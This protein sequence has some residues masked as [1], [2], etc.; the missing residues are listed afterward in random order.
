MYYMLARYPEKS[1]LVVF[2]PSN[3]PGREGA[4]KLRTFQWSQKSGDHLEYNLERLLKQTVRVS[5]RLQLE[6]LQASSL[7][8]T[9]K[10]RT[11]AD[12]TV[13]EAIRAQIVSN[14]RCLSLDREPALNGPGM[15]ELNTVKPGSIPVYGPAWRPNL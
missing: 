5:R 3:G 6:G 8:R 12:R 14:S 11:S 4:L 7:G 10:D 1:N 13:R 2:S 9:V 15:K